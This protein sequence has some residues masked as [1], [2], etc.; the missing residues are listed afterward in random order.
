MPFSANSTWRVDT[1]VVAAEEVAEKIHHRLTPRYPLPYWIPPHSSSSSL[2][3]SQRKT[4][5]TISWMNHICQHPGVQVSFDVFEV[6]GWHRPL[7]WP[8]DE[9]N[10][11][12]VCKVCPRLPRELPWY[13]EIGVLHAYLLCYT[14]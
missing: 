5:L 4:C 3:W 11:V 12:L 6:F 7:G 1:K 13:L 14:H 2:L 10:L 8:I 9:F